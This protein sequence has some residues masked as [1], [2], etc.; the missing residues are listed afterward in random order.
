[1]PP[2]CVLNKA[3]NNICDS[4]DS[5]L[6][7]QHLL[8]SAPSSFTQYIDDS[9]EEDVDTLDGNTDDN[10]DDNTDGKTTDDTMEGDNSD[11]SESESDEKD[12]SDGEIV[13]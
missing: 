12:E 11:N 2:P 5:T 8:S 4:K 7:S 9:D 13:D 10:T 6:G 1:M 3:W